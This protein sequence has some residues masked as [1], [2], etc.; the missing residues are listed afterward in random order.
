MKYAFQTLYF[1]V[2]RHGV[3]R[4]TSSSVRRHYFAGHLE[5][6]FC[7]QP[8]SLQ[9]VVKKVDFGSLMLPKK[10]TLQKHKFGNPFIYQRQYFQAQSILVQL[11]RAHHS[12]ASFPTPQQSQNSSLGLVGVFWVFWYCG[13]SSAALCHSRKTSPQKTQIQRCIL[14]P[15]SI[16]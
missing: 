10:N 12:T 1:L 2:S 3:L 14:A 6:S 11:M 16:F 7:H 4:V 9:N 8:K 15:K 13:R 5:S